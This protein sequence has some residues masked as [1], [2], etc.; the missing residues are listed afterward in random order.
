MGLDAPPL[1]EPSFRL[2]QIF[3]PGK[4]PKKISLFLSG[5]FLLIAGIALVLKEWNSVVV[6]FNGMVGGVLAILGLIVLMSVK[7]RG[8]AP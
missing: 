1:E 4:M 6:I 5:S 7:V 8:E 2:N 3:D